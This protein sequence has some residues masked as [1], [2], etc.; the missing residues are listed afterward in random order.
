M[1]R[2]ERLVVL[3]AGVLLVGV[4]H[5]VL[6]GLVGGDLRRDLL[7]DQPADPVGVGPGDVAELVVEGLEDV[8]RAGRAPAPACARRRSVGTGSIS[9]SCVRQ[10]R[11]SSPPASRPGSCPC[12]WLRECPCDRSSSF[13]AGSFG[14][15][16]FRKIDSF[17]QSALVYG[18]ID[19]RKP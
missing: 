1:T 5:G 15:R 6:V 17:S 3:D 7:G 2:A 16:K 18:R 8:A 4:L 12:R 11:S 14:M 9:A 10:L 19:A 13:G